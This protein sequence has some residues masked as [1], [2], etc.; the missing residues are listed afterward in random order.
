MNEQQNWGHLAYAAMATLAGAITALSFLDW[1]KLSWAEI[2]MTLF[3]GSAF[4]W[5][6][7]P[8]L[9]GDRWGISLEN[10]RTLCFYMYMGATSANIFI[11]LIIRKAK[12]QFGLEEEA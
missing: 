10:R 3:V 11:P 9:I 1:K 2:A 12:K 6:C 7:V 5:F 4:A 8:Y